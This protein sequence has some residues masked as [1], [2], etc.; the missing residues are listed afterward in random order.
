MSTART[1]SKGCSRPICLSHYTDCNGQN[2]IEEKASD[3]D[4]KHIRLTPVFVD[5]I[6]VC[7]FRSLFSVT[8]PFVY[9]PFAVLTA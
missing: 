8:S 2:G 5:S 6:I 9:E 4:N 1:N 7:N 3:K